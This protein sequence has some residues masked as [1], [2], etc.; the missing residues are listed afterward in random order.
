MDE[1]LINIMF[2]LLGI[3]SGIILSIIALNISNKK[4]FTDKKRYITIELIKFADNDSLS[5]FTKEF[6]AATVTIRKVP[7]ELFY[8]PEVGKPFILG[9]YITASVIRIVNDNTFQTLTGN[10]YQ[11]RVYNDEK[12]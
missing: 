5:A 1:L 9:T 3:A 4:N 6:R 2:G 7:R 12:E 11:W 8:K 10:T